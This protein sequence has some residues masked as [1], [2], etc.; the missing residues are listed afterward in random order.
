MRLQNKNAIVTGAGNGIGRAIAHRFASEGANVTVAELEEDSG[1]ETVELIERAGGTA[2]FVWT[3]TS[4]SASVKAAVAAAVAAH[5]EVDVLVNNAAA[6][7]FG[8]IED[9]TQDGVTPDRQSEEEWSAADRLRNAADG[10][11]QSELLG[12]ND[13]HGLPRQ[14]RVDECSLEN[15]GHLLDSTGGDELV[16]ETNEREQWKGVERMAQMIQHVISESIDDAG[17]QNRVLEP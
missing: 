11:T 2:V 5:G 6:F 1:R 4:D 9:V 8:K 13:K 7:V 15:V 16:L 17:S 10:V 3:D 12:S 14:A